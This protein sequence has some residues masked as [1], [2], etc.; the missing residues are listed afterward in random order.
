MSKCYTLFMKKYEF[1]F[2]RPKSEGKPVYAGSPNT[3][4]LP[5]GRMMN[6]SR[7]A[8]RRSVLGFALPRPCFTR[9]PEICRTGSIED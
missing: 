9:C 8:I 4:A 5:T 3:E 2:V 7:S 6:S 1:S